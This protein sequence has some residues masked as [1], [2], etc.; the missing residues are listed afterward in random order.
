MD[1]SKGNDSHYPGYSMA[2]IY[3]FE[4]PPST[5]HEPPPAI[6]MEGWGPPPY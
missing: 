4:K 2:T 5:L 3:S 1:I 6:S